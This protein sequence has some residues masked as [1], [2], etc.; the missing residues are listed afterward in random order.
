MEKLKPPAKANPG[1]SV[2]EPGRVVEQGGTRSSSC[3]GRDRR[4]RG[5]VTV[6]ERGSKERAR[7]EECPDFSQDKGTEMVRSMSW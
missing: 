6:G 2:L 1:G 7:E 5:L 4:Q 3:T